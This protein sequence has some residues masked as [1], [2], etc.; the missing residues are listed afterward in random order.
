M[1]QN[2]E[3][4]K[5]NV[6]AYRG[7]V[8][9]TGAPPETS[10]AIQTLRGLKDRMTNRYDKGSIALSELDRARIESMV[11]AVEAGPEIV[12]PSLYW[13]KLNRMN[14]DQLYYTSYDNFKRTLA[15]NYFTFVNILARRC[16]MWVA[17]PAPL[18]R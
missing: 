2:F 1:Q 6:V 12:R 5:R 18:R 9:E 4:E 8:E 13:R 17:C 3:P 11:E 14:I 15:L 10:A 16:F 7:V